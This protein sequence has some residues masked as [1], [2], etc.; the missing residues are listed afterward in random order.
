MSMQGVI[1]AAG[2]GK[3]LRPL[4]YLMS[5]AMSPVLGR[6]IIHHLIEDC[7]AATGISDWIIV[8]SRNNEDIVRYFERDL[9]GGRRIAEGIRVRFVYQTEP[10]GMAH[11]LKFARPLLDGPFLLAACDTLYPRDHLREIHGAHLRM[12]ANATL[13]LMRIPVE[14]FAKTAIVAMD[15]AGLISR[16]IEKPTPE[17]AP[18]DMGSLPLYLF[19]GKVL[20]YLDEVPRSARGEYEIQNAIQMIADRDGGVRG[21]ETRERYSLTSIEDLLDINLHYLRERVGGATD[22][23]LLKQ[24]PGV[25]FTPPVSVEAGAVIGEGSEIGPLAHIGRNVHIGASCRL[26]EAVVL[27]D[28]HV[29]DGCVAER[30]I[31]FPEVP[32]TS[33]I[34]K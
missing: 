18:S 14:Q 12:K 8:T 20:P 30:Q 5:K 19:S 26:R 10:L 22:S 21:V 1:L 13:S 6:P 31:F 33:E 2:K 34:V 11:A 24:Y 28:T 7:H 16:I 3:R 15:D 4:S 23:G 17:E 9:E 29:E 25:R 27:A 32:E